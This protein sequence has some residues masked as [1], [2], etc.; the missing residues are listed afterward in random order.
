MKRLVILGSTGSIGRQTLELLEGHDHFEIVGL[1]GGSN[2]DL[3]TQQVQR[4][5]PHLVSC[6]NAPL[7]LPP[8]S[9]AVEYCSLEE[10]A[11]APEADLV[12]IG[13]V[14]KVGLGPALAALNAGKMVALANKEV[15]VMAGAL[16]RQA[17]DENGGML[18]PVDSEHSALWQCLVGEPG[19]PWPRI[20]RLVLTASGGALRDLPLDALAQV[21]PEQALQHPT[22]K[23][24]KKITVDSATL[25]NKGFEVMEAHWLFS[26][27]WE[28]IEVLQ[29]RESIVHSFVEYPDGVIKAQL[30]TPDM[31]V[32]LQYAL[33]YPERLTTATKPLDLLALGELTFGSVDMARYPC[34]ALAVQTAHT[35]GTAPAVLSAADDAAVAAF[36]AGHLGFADIYAAVADTVEQHEV[37]ANPNLEEILEAD[38]WARRCVEQRVAVVGH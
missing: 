6:E 12:V 21:S 18:L 9:P 22:W 13:T 7:P 28:Q 1:A 20:R 36:L 10:M 34:L 29:H 16:V 38:Q 8:G 5:R 15:F 35:G 37:I 11:V 31:R 25:M 30:G 27:P 19:E 4:Y 26:Y 2:V 17:A 33:T 32:P 14:G 23:M 3:L 24:G